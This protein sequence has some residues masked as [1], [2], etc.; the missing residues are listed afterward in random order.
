MSGIQFS[1]SITIK[2]QDVTDDDNDRSSSKITPYLTGH[3]LNKGFVQYSE[4]L[5]I[6]ICFSVR[7]HHK[8]H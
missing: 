6:Q 5:G 8:K 3:P 2:G 4:A 7:G 1:T